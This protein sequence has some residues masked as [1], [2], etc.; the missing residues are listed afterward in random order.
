MSIVNVHIHG[1]RIINSK[2]HLVKPKHIYYVCGPLG[3][4]QLKCSIKDHVKVWL[5]SLKLT[6]HLHT[7][8]YIKDQ[9]I[10]LCRDSLR[11]LLTEKKRFLLFILNKIL[12][13]C[14]NTFRC[15]VDKP[16]KPRL[17]Y[18]IA[19]KDLSNTSVTHSSVFMF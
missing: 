17:G 12:Y 11:T 15:L 14:F 10:V 18:E 19:V 13:S 3:S 4:Y 9:S 1:C 8:L 6:S 2:Y 7:R 5:R 16:A